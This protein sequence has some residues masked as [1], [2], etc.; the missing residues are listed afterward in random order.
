MS[1]W[2]PLE[3]VTWGNLDNKQYH[4]DT[5]DFHILEITGGKAGIKN[6]H[7]VIN[8]PEFYIY[9]DVKEI[10]DIIVKLKEASGGDKKWRMLSFLGK[11]TGNWCLKYLR[12]YY[13]MGYGSVIC[14]AYDAPLPKDWFVDFQIDKEVLSAH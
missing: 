6:I 3:E 4:V 7:N 13:V 2:K 12:I 10:R 14:D 8:R 11:P 9:K 5:R 1:N